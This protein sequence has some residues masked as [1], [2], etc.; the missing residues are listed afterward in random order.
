[1]AG[2]LFLG[3][4]GFAF[5]EWKGSF[6]P[7]GLKSDEMLPY[8]AGRFPS[9][10]INYTFRRI[11]TEEVFRT[12][13]HRTPD[14]FRFALKAN[15]RITHFRR[16]RDADGDVSDFL[17]PA[18]TLG[19]R[20]GPILFQCPPTLQYDRELIESFLGRLPSALRYAFEFRHPS[21]AEARPILRDRGAAWC[22]AE[23][24]A[25]EADSLPPIEAP[26]G[27]L[28]LRKEE[29]T[30]DELRRWADRLGSAMAEGLDVYAYLKHEKGVAAPRHAERIRELLS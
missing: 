26:F 13:A 5:P 21:W 29:Y 20:L 9:V 27:F 2:T 18:R 8:Y 17:D 4:S 1:M 16:L 14:W 11:P 28:R 12:W 30:E 10:E 6:Y 7:E 24:D 25:T 22:I 19:D 23:T 3:T 15:Q